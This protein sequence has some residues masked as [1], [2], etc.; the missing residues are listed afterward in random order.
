MPQINEKNFKKALSDVISNSKDWNCKR[1]NKI[2][3]LEPNK[4]RRVDPSNS[5]SE[6]SEEENVN[7]FY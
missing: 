7:D 4:N 6:I 1:K 5:N 2:Q 3:E